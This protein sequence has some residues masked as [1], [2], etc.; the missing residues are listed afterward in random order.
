MQ[1]K[2]LAQCLSPKKCLVDVSSLFKNNGSAALPPRVFTFPK[3]IIPND[4][5]HFPIP[6]PDKAGNLSRPTA[7]MPYFLSL[8]KKQNTF[9]PFP[10]LGLDSFFDLR[11]IFVYAIS[12][13]DYLLLWLQYNPCLGFVSPTKFCPAGLD[14]PSAWVSLPQLLTSIFLTAVSDLH[15]AAELKHISQRQNKA[16]SLIFE[17]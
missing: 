5:P 12:S 11:I 14:F 16:S 2:L 9:N 4:T 15:P 10:T 17:E 13:N 1:A 8:T 6:C 7:Y 3:R